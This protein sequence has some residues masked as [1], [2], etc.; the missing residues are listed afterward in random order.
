[1]LTKT[2]AM[3]RSGLMRTSLTVTIAP[4]KKAMPLLRIIS[5]MSRCNSRATLSCLVPWGLL[6]IDF[7]DVVVFLSLLGKDVLAVYDVRLGEL[8]GNVGKLLFVDTE[9]VALNHLAGLS[10]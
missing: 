2:F 7:Y 5:A 8:T 4:P 3:L 10:L 9:P 1:M 6:S